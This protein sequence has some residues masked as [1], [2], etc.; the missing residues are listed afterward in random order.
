M[1]EWDFEIERIE[2]FE[3]CRY[4]GHYLTVLARYPNVVRRQCLC[5][6]VLPAVLCFCASSNAGPV[7]ATEIDRLTLPHVSILMKR[8]KI[9]HIESDA[10]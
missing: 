5:C 2:R 3:K 10:I 9:F 1:S 4:R 7:E 8:G 6:R